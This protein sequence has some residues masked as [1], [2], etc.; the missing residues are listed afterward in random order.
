M[1]PFVGPMP[2]RLFRT[3]A[4]RR[5]MGQGPFVEVKP[6]I[7]IQSPNIAPVVNIELGSLPLSIGLFAGS[8]VLFYMK[9]QVPEGWPKTVSLLGGAGLAAAGIMNLVAPKLLAN[10]SKPAVPTATAPAPLPPAAGPV[11]PGG[12]GPAG[13]Q[14]YS[15]SNAQAFDNV[16]GRI[17]TPAD[18]STVDIWPWSTSYPVRIQLSNASSAPV[19]FELELTA[20]EDPAPVGAKTFSSLPVQVSLNPGQI[21]DVDVNMPITSWGSL[22]DYVDIMLTARKRRAPG[23]AAQLVDTRSFVVE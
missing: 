12:A 15:A 10:E 9:G 18:F 3:P 19:T 11:I 22:V 6:D 5:V 2:F 4:P 17:S 23:E 13:P 8:A 20:E 16:T 21:K 1:R 14:A 7:T